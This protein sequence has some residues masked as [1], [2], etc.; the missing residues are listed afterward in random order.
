MKHPILSAPPARYRVDI[1]RCDK[2]PFIA[3]KRVPSGSTDYRSPTALCN[4]FCSGKRNIKGAIARECRWREHATCF[5]R[6]RATM[7]ALKYSTSRRH[8][9]IVR[10]EEKDVAMPIYDRRSLSSSLS[11]S[12][13]LSIHL[14]AVSYRH[15]S[16]NFRPSSLAY[17]FVVVLFVL[18][19]FRGC[20]RE[21]RWMGHGGDIS[22]SEKGPPD[23]FFNE[24][25][26]ER[27]S[28]KFHRA[29]ARGWMG[30]LCSVYTRLAKIFFFFVFFVF[31]F[32]FALW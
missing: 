1:S 9:P 11:L 24:A 31:L 30:A 14:S 23:Y 6:N 7:F 15:A 4:T 22:G 26:R 10:L 3:P 27:V 32:G 20:A 5:R 16:T 2:V 17:P 21:I 29:S 19:L 13:S 8:D 25:F 18:L 28:L 12:L